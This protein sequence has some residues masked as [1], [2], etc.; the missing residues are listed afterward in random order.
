M[1]DA[2]A[3]ARRLGEP[4]PIAQTSWAFAELQLAW[5]DTREARSLLE[6]ALALREKSAFVP[7]SSGGATTRWVG[8][9]V[10]E[11]DF[12]LAC[13]EFALAADHARTDEGGSGWPPTPL[14]RSD[15]SPPLPAI[16]S[17]ACVWPRRASRSPPDAAPSRPHHGPDE[18]VETA[19][20]AGNHPTGAEE[21]LEELLRSLR[22]QAAFDGLPTPS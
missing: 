7:W 21:L 4:E 2:L 14:P 11:H 10:A 15:R 19:I 20:L 3:M 6:D 12:P 16:P 18:Y 22:D 5:G 13:A 9:A 1:R 8:V 17:G